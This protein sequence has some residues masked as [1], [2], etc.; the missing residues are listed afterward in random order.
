MSD[1]FVFGDID[2]R[3]Y[4]G[5]YVYFDDVDAT[6]SRVG[7]FIEIPGRN[8]SFY[9]DKG[10][11]EDVTHTYD[12]VAL[13]MEAGRDLINAISSQV[14]YHRLEDSFNPDEFYSAV[15]TSEVEPNIPT[16]REQMT[17]KLMF[18]RKPQRFLTSGEEEQTAQATAIS[19]TNPTLFDASPLI[20][21]VSNNG[22]NVSFNVENS[23]Y[24]YPDRFCVFMENEDVGD[25]DLR[26]AAVFWSDSYFNFNKAL[27]NDTDIATVEVGA[28]MEKFRARRSSDTVEILNVVKQSGSLD[29]DAR[30]YVVGYGEP[31]YVKF[32]FSQAF[33]FAVGDGLSRSTNIYTVNVKRTK[34]DSTEVT[35]AYK[36]E[37]FV[38]AISMSGNTE[39][40][41]IGCRVASDSPTDSQ[42][43][44]TTSTNGVTPIVS[45]YGYSTLPAIQGTMYIDMETGL[46]YKY[47]ADG[48]LFSLNKYVR[49]ENDR[50][51]L[52]PDLM[53]L[54]PGLN[55]F[56]FYGTNSYG[57]TPRWWKI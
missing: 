33:E 19:L 45:A 15:F 16:D 49:F 42:I 38:Q 6:P 40:F 9:L 41:A 23:K 2:T 17:F 50:G 57:I 27:F 31:E 5:I 29:I 10:R 22:G 56:V 12:I 21:V 32:D 54:T 26:N 30:I 7:E 24:E 11:Y 44:A 35:T 4:E 52:R 46:A 14:G 48:N 39:Q 55:E 25:I 43:L 37:V 1:Y 20:K 18:T 51:D 3:N 13:T 8:G 34:S 47:D 53:V 36:L 28:I